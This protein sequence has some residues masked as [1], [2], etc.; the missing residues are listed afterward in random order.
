MR[1][2]STR[3]ADP[4]KTYSFKDALELGYAPDGGLFV[5]AA[6]LPPFQSAQLKAWVESSVAWVDVAVAVLRKF[7]GR[8]EIPDA[9][10]LQICEAAVAGYEDP[11]DP[12]PVVRLPAGAA[13]SAAPLLLAELFHGPTFCFKDLGQ[14]LTIRLLAFFQTQDTLFEHEH[15]PFEGDGDVSATVKLPITAF[16]STTG[17]TGPAALQ[18]A[19]DADCSNLRVIVAHPEGQVSELQRRQMTTVASSSVRTVLFQGGGDDLDGP[20]KELTCGDSEGAKKLR[21]KT[22]LVGLN[23]FN[24]GRPAAQVCHYFWTYLNAARDQ[25]GRGTLPTIDFAVPSGA[26]GNL[27]AGLFAK[28]LGLPIGRLISGTN[29]N[30]VTCRAFTGEGEFRRSPDMH[31]NLAEAMNIQVGFIC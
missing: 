30:D 2:V 21:E 11:R 19:A 29:V 23:S 13:A 25:L 3:A 4:S 1:Y 9:A 8:D 14:Q 5:P 28:L 24:I 22:K 15:R 18:A 10:L 27:T 17:D 16:V 31:R 20:I 7:I 26:L 6:P 12:F